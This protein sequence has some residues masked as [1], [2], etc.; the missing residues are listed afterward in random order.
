MEEKM[1]INKNDVVSVVPIRNFDGGYMKKTYSELI[2]EISADEID[3]LYFFL[4]EIAAK[5]NSKDNKLN[6]DI[7]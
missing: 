2:D 5:N 4:E 7:F 1:L 3:E 6:L